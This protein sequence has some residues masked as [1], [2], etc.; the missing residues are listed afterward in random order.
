MFLSP[1]EIERLTG[2]KRPSAQLRWLRKHGY[3]LTVNGLGEP[4]V[5]VSEANRKLV[6][7]TFTRH[8]EPNWGALHGP[9]AGV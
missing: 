7:G 5:A 1:T 4:I 8:E 2:R 6:G 3:R 9:Q